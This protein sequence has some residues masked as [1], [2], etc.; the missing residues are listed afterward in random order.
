MFTLQ[1]W[2]K[3]ETWRVSKMINDKFLNE[4]FGIKKFL[5]ILLLL[6]IIIFFIPKTVSADN[7]Y[8]AYFYVDHDGV[9]EPYGEDYIF[10]GNF[11]AIEKGYIL[12]DNVV[13]NQN[14]KLRSFVPKGTKLLSIKKEEDN[15]LVNFSEEIKNYGG[16][17]WEQDLIKQLVLTGLQVDG[18]ENV[19][20]LINGKLD[21]LAE[22]TTVDK[23]ERN[24][25]VY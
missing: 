17:S 14:E 2:N 8:K 13:H 15:L 4:R 5:K 12:F 7:L 21:T 25:I 9:Y 3:M 18:V 10:Y 20:L 1:H 24:D 22:G 19:T 11:L 16:S 23:F 6:L